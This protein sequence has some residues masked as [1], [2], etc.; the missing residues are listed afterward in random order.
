MKALMPQVKEKNMA[1]PQIQIIQW[2]KEI[3]KLKQFLPRYKT[4]SQKTK[5]NKALFMEK[6][7]PFLYPYRD[8]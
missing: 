4:C 8:A 2:S 3:P 1:A 7:A 5:Q 6:C